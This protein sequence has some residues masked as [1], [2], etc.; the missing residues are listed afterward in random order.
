MKCEDDKFLANCHIKVEERPL[1]L[2]LFIFEP[3]FIT[4]LFSGC[5]AGLI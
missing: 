5:S 1:F 4:A 2:T 3:S